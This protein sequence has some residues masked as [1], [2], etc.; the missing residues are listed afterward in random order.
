[1]DLLFGV[2][3]HQPVNNFFEVV[4][5]ATE[6]SYYPFLKTLSNYKN[7]KISVHFSGW[8]LEWL[9]KYHKDTFSI[10]K[11]LSDNGQI[12]FFTAGFYEPILS[13]IPEK[14]AELQILKLNKFIRDNFGQSPKGLWLTERVWEDKIIKLLVN[15][16]IKYVVVDDYHFLSS[17]YSKEMLQG[18]FL[19]ES[20]GNEVAIFPIDKKLRYLVPFKEI[21]EI[22]NYIKRL[23]CGIIFDDGE[24]F[25]LWP[26]TFEWVYEKGWLNR[27]FEIVQNSEMINSLKFSDFFSA[28]PPMGR[29]YLPEVSY[30]EMGQ[31]SLTYEDAHAMEEFIENNKFTPEEV[32]KFFKGGIW[33]NFFVKYEESNNI[34]KR[35]LD[36]SSRIT[37]KT[38]DDELTD[39]LLQ[40]QC[41]DCLWHGVFGG[42]YLPNLRDNAYI[43]VNKV[44]NLLDSRE[45]DIE[46]RI[47]DYNFDGFN[48]IFLKNKN[49][50]AII[51]L[52]YGGALFE[53]SD[54]DTCF[55]IMNTLTRRKEQYHDDIL[56]SEKNKKSNAKVETIH[57][58][59]LEAS[60]E[61]K[62][63]LI[64]DN[65]LKY[66]F[67]E[68]FFDKNE[69]FENFKLNKVTNLYDFEEISLNKN[70]VIQQGFLKIFKEKF[71]V[72]IEK[73]FL[74]NGKSLVVD[75]EVFNGS[76][77]FFDL[78]FATE[79]NFFFPGYTNKGNYFKIKNEKFS[80]DETIVINNV[81][82]I[83]VFDT[84]INKHVII[85]CEDKFKLWCFPYYSVSKSEKSIDRIYQGTSFVII[86]PFD[87]KGKESR[88]YG[89]VIDLE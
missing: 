42:I 81:N 23:S 68:L 70:K 52:Q 53:L 82:K 27:F 58:I 30:Y 9:K 22:L 75:F 17:G 19:T 74:L 56:N 61:I 2:H 24:K 71:P 33:K 51:S 37:N 28:H 29:V 44:E 87:Y 8:L 66:S 16:G 69:T 4:K 36:L 47:L 5:E 73:D 20:E 89:F 63:D 50:I 41:N 77:L 18:Y 14:D 88:K 39:Y 83:E 31:W 49:I 85:K 10:L 78:N 67:V 46:R 62:E 38:L 40:S 86:F 65:H 80:M 34:H 57:D 45:S 32:E 1:M 7:I 43:A 35:M 6:K 84:V 21:D 76:E 64:F 12:E 54:R 60:D 48:E 11:E 26:K 25:G 55:N 72:K 3:S 59:A 13:V 15:V 79:L